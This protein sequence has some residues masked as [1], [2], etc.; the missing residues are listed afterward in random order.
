MTRADVRYE[1]PM[2]RCQ[3]PGVNDLSPPRRGRQ[4][5]IAT[6]CEPVEHGGIPG[7]VQFAGPGTYLGAD[8]AR[9]V[10]DRVSLYDSAGG[11]PAVLSLSQIERAVVGD[12]KGEDVGRV[13]ETKIPRTVYGGSIFWSTR[14][15]IR[16][17]VR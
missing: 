8:G 17:D 16:S 13:A 14:R 4:V 11:L 1:L 10:T 15:T 5:A 9:D 7:K 12:R 2:Q 6:L 3:V